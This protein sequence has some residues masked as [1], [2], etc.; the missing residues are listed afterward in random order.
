MNSLMQF[1]E[2]YEFLTSFYSIPESL[3][4]N[5]EAKLRYMPLKKGEYFIKPGD[6]SGKAAFIK[7]GLCRQ[8]YIDQ[9]GKEHGKYFQLP[10][11]VAI[12]F[13]EM[14]QHQPSRCYIQAVVDSEVVALSHPNFGSLFDVDVDAQILARRIA[15]RFFIEKDQREY[16]FL[17]FTAKQRYDA[18]LDRYS[19]VIDLIPQYQIASY[20]GITSVAL[21]RLLSSKDKE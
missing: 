5:S 12:P 16:E 17:H 3:L 21:S 7:T 1:R 8:F 15:E 19:D 14:L 11:T 2:V 20:I 13:S 6:H 9:N 10:G 4:A 18:F